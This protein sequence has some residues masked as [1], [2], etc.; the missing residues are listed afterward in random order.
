MAKRIRI[1][2]GWMI[3]P[4]SSGYYNG[5]FADT[6]DMAW[7]LFEHTHGAFMILRKDAEARGDVAVKVV[8]LPAEEYER[9]KAASQPKPRRK[10]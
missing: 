2:R 4:P 10:K 8:V 6:K 9:L 5:N 1:G 3:A 7:F